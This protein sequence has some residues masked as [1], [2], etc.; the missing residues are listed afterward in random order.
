MNKELIEIKF[1][2]LSDVS[3]IRYN[4]GNIIFLQKRNSLII[5][6]LGLIIVAFLLFLPFEIR[7]SGV[8][9]ILMMA[10][11]GSLIVIVAF[12]LFIIEALK[13]GKLNKS[14]DEFLNKNSK[15]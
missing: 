5:K 10:G 13:L 14:L 8:N 7:Y 12:I 9:R 3:K 2:K 11:I 6:I 4:L 1:K 15:K